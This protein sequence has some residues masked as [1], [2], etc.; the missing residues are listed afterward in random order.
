MLRSTA[1]TA[2][3]LATSLLACDSAAA[4]L[5]DPPAVAAATSHG[6]GG[7]GG[8][9][10]ALEQRF[11]ELVRRLRESQALPPAQPDPAKTYA[12][13]V[14]ENDPVEGPADARITLVEAYEFMCPYCARA[15]PTVEA[16]KAKYGKDLRVVSKYLVL[17]GPEAVPPALYAC[18]AAK[19]GKYG[20]YKNLLWSSLFDAQLK[21]QRDQFTLE[22]LDA[23]ATQAGLDLVALKNDVGMEAT[24]ETACM[25]WIKDSMR[26]LEKF[27][28]SGTPA[29]F[30]N[31]RP[32]LG[33]YP[34]EAF[35]KV[36]TEELAKA[37]RAIEGGVAAAD[38]YQV[39][40]IGK[41][42]R[43][44]VDTLLGAP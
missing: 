40:V 43:E 33:A 13:P 27:N 16:L 20:P 38:Y 1:L 14:G 15:N 24:A 21:V 7:G 35:E 44:V 29:F 4:R 39:A 2:L 34:Q 26:D 36:I 37:N 17:H 6:G 28:V 42:E 12:V 30:V 5:G 3:L 8:D 25:T 31:G 19:Q 32:L 23:L 22:N 18:A 10:G 11:E 9:V 41:G